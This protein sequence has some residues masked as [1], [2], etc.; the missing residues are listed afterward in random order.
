VSFLLPSTAPV[1]SSLY[2]V[3]HFF[4][5]CVLYVDSTPTYTEKP[6]RPIR[7]SFKEGLPY[8]PPFPLRLSASCLPA[9]PQIH[10]PPTYSSDPSRVNFIHLASPLTRSETFFYITS[11]ESCFD[12]SS[13]L[14]YPLFHGPLSDFSPF[15]RIPFFFVLSKFCLRNSRSLATRVAGLGTE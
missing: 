5:F 12:Y 3:D 6:T 8:F 7:V 10:F 15:F 13:P 1:E 4:S 9:F 2:A 11:R 14:S